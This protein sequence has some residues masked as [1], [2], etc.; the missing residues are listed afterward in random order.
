MAVQSKIVD[1]EIIDINQKGNLLTLKLGRN[2]NQ[3]GDDWNDAPYNSN[4]GD[5]YDEY[6]RQTVDV[7]YNSAYTV[8]AYHE[9]NNF[10]NVSLSMLDFVNRQQPLF[11][12]VKSDT[13]VI[14]DTIYLGDKISQHP[15]MQTL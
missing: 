6:V 3:W 1:D 13:F 5:V 7:V 15:L 9:F 11:Y 14:S 2:G 10:T 4:A 8:V 12:I